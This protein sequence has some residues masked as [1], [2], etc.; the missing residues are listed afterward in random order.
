MTPRTVT[1]QKWTLA[2]LALTDAYTD[3]ILN[4]QAIQCTS[5][6]LDFYK[7]TAGVFFKWVEG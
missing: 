3:F 2:S 1:Q 4:R 7:Y 6:A 5:A